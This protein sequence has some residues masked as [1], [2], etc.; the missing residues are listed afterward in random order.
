M[1]VSFG[2]DRL[3]P[4]WQDSVVCI[5]T[6][7]GVHLGHA[8][9]ISQAI[10]LARTRELPCI[11]VTFD[12]HPA[13]TLA[14]ER[15]PPA[16]QGLESNLREFE[17]LGVAVSVVL[18]FDERLSQTTAQEFL[19]EILGRR[20]RA[21]HVVIGYDFALGK[22]REGNPEWLQRHIDTTVVPAFNLD[23]HRVSSSTIR[24]AVADGS[25]DIANRLLGRPFAIEGTVVA[26][27]KLGRQLGF[28]T[29][30]IARA[31]N[32]VLPP[33]GVYRGTCETRLGTFKAAASIGVRPAVGG[34]ART[35]E[36]F[37]LDYPGD[38]IYGSAVRLNL[39]E[40]LREERS[41]P[42]L[43]ALKDQMALDVAL[44]AA[45]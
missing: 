36:A 25:L 2:L 43:D 19:D 41:F 16:I 4:E 14:P 1:L 12:R 5:G 40:R 15:C 10:S 6:F 33:D 9:V 7:D 22:G 11:L 17:R 29:V 38:E 32:T 39:L 27:Q 44:V 30:N 35:I 42:S 26:G 13:A 8:E 23:G 45:R 37:L 20:L 31:S 34:T 21:R 3:H 28:P 24:K 18:A